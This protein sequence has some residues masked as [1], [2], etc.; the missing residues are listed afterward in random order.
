MHPF[1]ILDAPNLQDDFYINV[2]DWGSNYVLSVGLAN[3]IYL[4]NFQTNQIHRLVNY[5]NFNSVTSIKW[6]KA[7]DLLAVS[8]KN[9]LVQLWD[10]NKSVKLT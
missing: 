2:L 5:Q 6:D 7:G 4:W 3:C 10:V 9:G 1:K 8:A